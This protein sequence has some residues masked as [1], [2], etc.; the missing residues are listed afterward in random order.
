MNRYFIEKTDIIPDAKFNGRAKYVMVLGKNMA[1]RYEQLKIGLNKSSNIEHQRVNFHFTE[2]DNLAALIDRNSYLLAEVSIPERSNVFKYEASGIYSTDQIELLNIRIISDL[3]HWADET[4]CINA[5]ARNGCAYSFCRVRNSK[6][7]KLVLKQQPYFIADM[8]QTEELCI[9]AVRSDGRALR[10]VK[11]QTDRICLEAVRRTGIAIGFVNVQTEEICMAAVKQNGDALQLV[12][13]QTHAICLVA[14]T[15]IGTA[16][17][18]VRADLKTYDICIAAV[19][20]HGSALKYVPEHHKTYEMCLTAIR[21][22]GPLEEVPDHHKTYE[23]CLTAVKYFGNELKHVP[24]KFK[25]PELCEAAVLC[26]FGVGLQY[27]PAELQSDRI[28]ALSIER[29]PD[30]VQFIKRKGG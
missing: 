29:Y 18:L 10:N 11:H 26:E 23:I 16:L 7:C 5:V 3:P 25:T 9:T 1:Y 28:I 2:F 22:R 6:I 24:Y 13:W 4:F 15:Q 27:V 14:V 30:T 8:E 21:K 12:K 17:D 19:N 20:Q